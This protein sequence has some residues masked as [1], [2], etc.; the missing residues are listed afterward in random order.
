MLPVS[1]SGLTVCYGTDQAA[2]V[3]YYWSV[4]PL[5]GPESHQPEHSYAAAVSLDYS[6]S[7]E[8]EGVSV[9]GCVTS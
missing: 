9:C 2:V 8:C 3:M 7:V 6:S 5:E 4:Y 1:R